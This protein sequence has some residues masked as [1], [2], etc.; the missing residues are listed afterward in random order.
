MLISSVGANW[1]LFSPEKQTKVVP[2]PAR[3]EGNSKGGEG[4]VKTTQQ[5]SNVETYPH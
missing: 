3:S 5:H 1:W 2:E 4:R